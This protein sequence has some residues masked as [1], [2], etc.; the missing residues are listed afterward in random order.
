MIRLPEGYD[1][2]PSVDALAAARGVVIG[3]SVAVLLWA[4][5]LLWLLL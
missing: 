5:L 3:M 4:G 1:W 2:D